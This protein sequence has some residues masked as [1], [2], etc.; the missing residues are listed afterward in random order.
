[1]SESMSPEKNTGEKP[2][3]GYVVAA[4]MFFVMFPA[5]LILNAASVFYVPVSQDLG[6]S[7]SMYGAVT[8]IIQLT[9]GICAP[10]LY[11]K[12]MRTFNVRY[13]V[14]AALIVEAIAFALRA[15]AVNIYMIYATSV[16]ISFPM[17]ILLAFSIPQL[18]N[19]WFPKKTGTMI[20]IVSAAQGIGGMLFSYVGSIVIASF[21]WRVCFAAFSAFSLIFVPIVLL[22]V[23]ATPAEKGLQP[24]GY[25]QNDDGKK[26]STP[27]LS[28]ISAEKAFRMLPFYLVLCTVPLIAFLTGISFFFNA[29]SQSIGMD[30]VFAGIIASVLQAGTMFFKLTL[31]AV[32]DK[33]IRLGGVYFIG[34]ALVTFILFIFAG[35]N[36]VAILIAS[37]LFGGVYSATNLYGPLLVK[38]VFGVR[39]FTNI[40]S[41]VTG[42]D[43]LCGGI[44]SMLWGV[45][46]TSA[47]YTTGFII[48]IPILVVMLTLVFALTAVAPRLRKQWTTV[49]ETENSEVPAKA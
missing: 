33:N 26:A 9:T 44:G 8:S 24:L 12:I 32:S 3:Y 27:V 6:I 28:G 23:R 11:S 46:A 36:P 15:V 4:V 5:S 47:G 49:D 2:Y 39:D 48:A 40:W 7:V 21:G 25:E 22:F 18:M 29:Y 30:A 10:T 38:H 1:M 45:I 16:L 14:A 20:G 42:M 17:S 43:T 31:G 35:T 34:A 13:V 19:M 41:K 37:F